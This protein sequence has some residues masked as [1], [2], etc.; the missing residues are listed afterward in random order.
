MLPASVQKNLSCQLTQA[1][2]V[3]SWVEDTYLLHCGG[4][5]EASGECLSRTTKLINEWVNPLI[6]PYHPYDPYDPYHPINQSSSQVWSSQVKTTDF[7]T[8]SSVHSCTHAQPNR[9]L[10]LPPPP[11]LVQVRLVREW[12]TFRSMTI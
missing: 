1:R 6:I 4:S 2:L 12:Q 7:L 9:K 8:R 10:F 11:G 5:N 3:P